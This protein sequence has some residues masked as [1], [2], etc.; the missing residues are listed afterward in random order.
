MIK[1]NEILWSHELYMIFAE[2]E[3]NKKKKIFKDI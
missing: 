1:P 2:M 3:I